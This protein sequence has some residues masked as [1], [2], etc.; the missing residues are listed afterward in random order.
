M[1]KPH[2]AS[3]WALCSPG[4]PRLAGQQNVR[5]YITAALQY[6]LGLAHHL[7]LRTMCLDRAGWICDSRIV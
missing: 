4:T 2:A 3:G 6:W 1:S 5:K 7:G